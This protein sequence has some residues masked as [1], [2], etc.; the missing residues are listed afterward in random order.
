MTKKK[1]KK[2]EVKARSFSSLILQV[3]QQNPKQRLNYKQISRRLEINSVNERNEIAKVLQTLCSQERL[4][5]VGHGKYKLK[6]H[7]G[8]IE[9]IVDMTPYG[10]AYI[11]T[12]E[13]TE[14]IFISQQNLNHALNGDK[15]KVSLFAKSMRRKLEGEVVEILT[16]AKENFVGTIDILKNFAFV[17]IDDKKMPYDIFV[18][19]SK[20]NEAQNG[21]KV[22]V[23]IT[24]WPAKAKNPFGEIVEVLGDPGNNET[25]MH[26]IL[27][28]FE[29]PYRFPAEVEQEA[30]DIPEEIPQQEIAKRRDFRDITT[31]T[32]DPVDAKDFD[33]ALSIRKNGELWEVGVHIADVSHY[34][35]PGTLLEEEGFKRATS[36]YLV[37]RVVP[38][39]PE[40]LSNKVCSLRPNEEKLCFSAVFELDEHANIK[41]EWFGRSIIN[42]DRRFTYEE[43]QEIIETQQGDFAEEVQILDRLAK[44][45]R[46]KRFKQGAIAFDK[47]E[48]KFNLD[49]DGKPLGVFF[50]ESKDSNKLI[51][52][53]MLLANKQVAEFINKSKEQRTFV[54][55]IH[56]QPDPE[57]LESFAKF[58]AKFGFKVNVGSKVAT[59]K[60]INNL[61]EEIKGKKESNIFATL[62]VR[63]MAKA[64][65]ST[66]NIGHYGLA[67]EN[68]SH[69]TSPIRRYPDVMAHRLLQ[70]YLD[71]QSSADYEE[72]E[73]KCRHSSEMEQRAVNAERASIKYKQVEFMQDKVGEEFDGVISG[74]TEWG[75]F[76]EL[77][78][79]QCEGL[80][81]MRDL[82]DDF[83]QYDDKNYCL[84]GKYSKKQYRLGD[85]IRVQIVNA[86]LGKKQLD[87]MIVQTEEDDMEDIE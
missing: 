7:S 83:Y 48:V 51:E 30:D 21:Q 10:S 5:E 82:D 27:A 52:E 26:A 3:F 70:R 39:L 68:Y 37:D 57:K 78:E 42:S 24:E 81:S 63:S 4:E 15:V 77:T 49:E 74:V 17:I 1:K 84:R 18:P 44:E 32:I 16:H 55:R 79:N 20:L 71:K 62:A 11:I 61:L 35:Q 31:F 41:S 76:V 25:E 60:S 87:F 43:A 22:I 40:K 69:F 12:E 9:G 6:I 65:Y 56:A 80:V 73:L 46:S 47:K 45:L 66:K 8:Y 86:D 85:D 50:K 38:M 28:E 36:V 67:F 2:R 23:K 53:F 34:V 59:S 19:L 13:F 54:Y 75:I 58:V 64:Q 14:D 33:D 72:F 29:L